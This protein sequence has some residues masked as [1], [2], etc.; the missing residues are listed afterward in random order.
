MEKTQSSKVLTIRDISRRLLDYHTDIFDL[1]K[2][3]LLSKEPEIIWDD[4]VSKYKKNSKERILIGDTLQTTNERLLEFIG[5]YRK[6]IIDY[7]FTYKLNEVSNEEATRKPPQYSTFLNG[8]RLKDAIDMKSL[9]SNTITSD[10][11]ITLVGPAIPYIIS[12]IVSQITILLDKPSATLFDTNLYGDHAF[13]MTKSYESLIQNRIK[14]LSFYAPFGKTDEFYTIVPI[15]NTI[16]LLDKE[17]KIVNE[18]LH[19]KQESLSPEFIIKQYDKI[20]EDGMILDTIF[21]KNDE[22]L[23]KKGDDNYKYLQIEHFWDLIT[24]ICRNS[25]ESYHT[26]STILVV[27]YGI[28]ANKIKELLGVLDARSFLIACIENIADLKHHWNDSDK[29]DVVAVKVSKYLQRILF[30][31]YH[32][33]TMTTTQTIFSD[34]DL[35]E[36]QEILE[37][38]I[39]IRNKP[40]SSEGFD[41]EERKRIKEFRETFGLNTETETEIVFLKE[42][43]KNIRK[44]YTLRKEKEKESG[45][46]RKTKKSIRRTHRKQTKN[47]LRKTKTKKV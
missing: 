24:G 30:C 2:K 47:I 26:I 1:D 23:P 18:K 5:A 9:G 28:Q 46:G 15:P 22:F 39:H 45:T 11:D 25:I 17:W 16:I 31:I 34:D 8:K 20:V 3:I 7:L 4:L 21:Y 44:E 41:E 35:R 29:T 14:G 36:Y 37:R 43:I 13:R 10:Y 38:I 33:Q 12:H 6:M 32:Y 19:K 42:L 40:S 27:V